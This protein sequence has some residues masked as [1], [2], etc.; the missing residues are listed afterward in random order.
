[1]QKLTELS[2]DKSVSGIITRQ[3][4]ACWTGGSADRQFALLKRALAE[5]EVIRVHRGLYC[6]ADKYLREKP[7]PLLFAQRIY[8]PSYISLEMAL[9]LHH[10]IP[11][12]V[13]T[14]T[15]TSVDRSR[16]FDTPLGHFSYTRVP[17]K[18]FYEAVTHVK[19]ATGNS[20]LLATPLKALAD[21]VYAHKCD[22]QSAE[23]VVQS[24]RVDE[25][26]L[27]DLEADTFDRLLTNYTSR[28]VQRFL[29]GL[30]KDLGK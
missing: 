3:E 28:R 15:N 9:S 1:M 13:Y 27:R 10:W 5:G 19:A 20:Y 4:V 7:N 23:P 18:T 14:I 16:E 26:V 30:R 17:Q 22:W 24:L 6:L 12:A 21:Y 11:E 2:L 8:G 25:S 29:T